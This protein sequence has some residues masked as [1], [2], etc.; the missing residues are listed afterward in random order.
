MVIPIIL[1]N[2]TLKLLLLL[3]I[4]SQDTICYKCN[5]DTKRSVKR[6]YQGEISLITTILYGNHIYI[7]ELEDKIE[8]YLYH[9]KGHT[10]Y[11]S[12][13]YRNEIMDN[14]NK[15]CTKCF[16]IGIFISL[17]RQKRLPF[18]RYDIKYF[19][20]YSWTN[21]P[22]DELDELDNN[23]NTIKYKFKN[24]IFPSNYNCSFYR[25]SVPKLV[26]TSHIITSF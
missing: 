15:I 22:P 21:V 25:E 1:I 11:H 6:L 17:Q 16:Q 2:N 8:E 24:Y 23:T 20:S 13:K 26:D 5:T 3:M 19:L 4:S 12:I 7:K 10:I 9:T 18:L 14:Y